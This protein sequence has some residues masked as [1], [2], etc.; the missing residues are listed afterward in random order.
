MY[1]NE[2]NII[3]KIEILVSHSNWITFLMFYKIFSLMMTITGQDILLK[4]TTMK[5]C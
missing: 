5:L 4:I 1:E 3:A 2:R